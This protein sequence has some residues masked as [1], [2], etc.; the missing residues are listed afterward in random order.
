MSPRP[1]TGVIFD[2][3]ALTRRDLKHSWNGLGLNWCMCRYQ[4]PSISQMLVGFLVKNCK[5]GAELS[6]DEPFKTSPGAGVAMRGSVLVRGFDSIPF[7][8]ICPFRSIWDPGEGSVRGNFL[9]WEVSPGFLLSSLLYPYSAGVSILLS[10]V[11][12][13]KSLSR[14][15]VGSVEC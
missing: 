14:T 2:S 7:W 13:D 11:A 9:S 4:H 10:R 5:V 12:V 8:S 6:P 1:H 3:S 15:F